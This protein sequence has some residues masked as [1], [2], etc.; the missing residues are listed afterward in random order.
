MLVSRAC[1]GKM[2]VSIEVQNM[3][4]GKKRQFSYRIVH[5]MVS[6]HSADLPRVQPPVTVAIVPVRRRKNDRQKP[7]S[8]FHFILSERSP[9]AVWSLSCLKLDSDGK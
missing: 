6:E 1:L 4:D 8:T 7:P 9:V 2:A 5:A 3:G